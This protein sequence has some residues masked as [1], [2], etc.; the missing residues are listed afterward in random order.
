MELSHV[1]TIL[2]A[3][4]SISLGAI[5]GSLRSKIFSSKAKHNLHYYFYGFSSM[6]MVLSVISSI[7]Y[8]RALFAP[9]WFA[10]VVVVIAISSSI[11]LWV[12]TKKYLIV[13]EVTPVKEVF[14]TDELN[15]IV[16][17]W[18]SNADK[19]EIKLFGGDLNFFGD[20]PN[21]MDSNSQYVHLRG[22][23]F[24]KVLI[25]CE[26]PGDPSTKIRYGKI[27]YDL[28]ST[29]LRF[30]KPPAADLKIRGRIIKVQN[31]SRLLVYE[32]KGNRLYKPIQTD[33][34]D[35]SGALYNAIWDLAWDLATPASSEVI[36]RLKK[37][38]RGGK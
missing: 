37:D 25:L 26:E 18:T 23:R 17:D 10:I 19:Q 12:I 32:K 24:R 34:G 20:G 29:E 2:L 31:V 3:G 7:I 35:S 16:N 4:A 28:E 38:F 27:L 13:E 30:Y 14:S 33:G 9:N 8:W 21:Q 6:V 5:F 11:A 15:P 22:L 36:E 1:T